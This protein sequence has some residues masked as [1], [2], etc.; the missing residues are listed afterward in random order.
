MFEG[1]TD[2]ENDCTE[3]EASARALYDAKEKYRELI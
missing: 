3:E 2:F 1:Q